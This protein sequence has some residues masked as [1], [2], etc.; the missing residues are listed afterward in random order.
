MAEK[1]S[2]QFTQMIILDFE[3]KVIGN[4]LTAEADFCNRVGDIF[5]LNPFNQKILLRSNYSRLL[6]SFFFLFE[7]GLDEDTNQKLARC[8]E[9]AYFLKKDLLE[10]LG[11]CANYKAFNRPVPFPKYC[12]MLIINSSNVSS[13]FLELYPDGIED[14]ELVCNCLVCTIH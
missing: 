5:N 10:K 11:W 2:E 14:K 13:N 3:D 9:E 7:K 6:L 4:N 1:L 12:W 8:V